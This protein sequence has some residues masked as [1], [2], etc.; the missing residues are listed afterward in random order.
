MAKKV[1]DVCKEII[2]ADEK[3]VI[4][5]TISPKMKQ[6]HY[7]HFECFRKNHEAKVQE[8]ARA[9]VSKMQG[10]AVEML[11]GIQKQFG[12]FAGG[13]Q[14]QKMLGINLKAE[15][16]TFE[17]SDSDPIIKE[18]EKKKTWKKKKKL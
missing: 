15:I 14:L 2:N 10:K 17:I 12:N 3:Y 11:G 4:L 13:D 7:F 16:P 1:C 18:E 6:E 9:I 8:K 5:S